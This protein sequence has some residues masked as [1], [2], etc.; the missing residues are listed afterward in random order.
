MTLNEGIKMFEWAAKQDHPFEYL[1]NWVAGSPPCD[2]NRA[3]LQFSGWLKELRTLRKE[4]RHCRL[5]HGAFFDELEKQGAL[6]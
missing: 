5:V 2:E 4:A 1:Y 3:L 6:A